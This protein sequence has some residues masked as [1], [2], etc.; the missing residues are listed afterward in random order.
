MDFGCISED[1]YTIEGKCSALCEA[2]SS[3]V[4]SYSDSNPDLGIQF[5]VR[6]LKPIAMRGGCPELLGRIGSILLHYCPSTDQFGRTLISLCRPLVVK[7]SVEVLEGCCDIF[8]CL[9]RKH[10]DRGEGCLGTAFLLDGIELESLIFVQ[11]NLGTCYK[12]LS[13]AC[14]G[15]SLH[16]LQSMVAD[17]RQK[18]V[19][20]PS[21]CRKALS[22]Q[23]AFESHSVDTSKIPDAMQL[24]CILGVFESML[25]GHLRSIGDQI[26]FS[27]E[28]NLNQAT[29]TVTS[30]SALSLHWM[31]LQVA[32]GLLQYRATQSITSDKVFP[33]FNKKGTSLLLR[34]LNRI[35]ASPTT[36]PRQ[37]LIEMTKAF[38]LGLAMSLDEE[39]TQKRHTRDYYADMEKDGANGVRSVHLHMCDAVTKERVVHD[40][41][42][43]T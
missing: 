14:H 40:R 37:E 1:S 42:L 21:I 8:Y 20:N 35:E 30:S 9:F 11:P 36:L 23:K 29:G 6:L 22:M 19:L 39:N 17:M 3:I 13:T 10:M 32:L 25:Q 15:A 7:K 26:A 18:N 38:S 12:A 33:A 31:L 5:A 41:M 16:L 27:L 34:T 24:V 43:E 2:A 4:S 28:S